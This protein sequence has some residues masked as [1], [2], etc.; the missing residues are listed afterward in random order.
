LIEKY[1]KPGK[2]RLVF[3]GVLNHAER[4]VHT[5]EAAHCAA[6]GGYGWH[7]HDLLFQNQNELWATS[8]DEHIALMKKYAQTFPEL[9]QAKFAACVE[10]REMLKTVQTIDQEQRARGITFQPIF[11]VGTARLAGAQPLEAFTKV[12]DAALV[13]NP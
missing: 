4:S 9:D 2:L 1:V 6:K 3:R 12:I 11:E 8:A 10:N 5:T 13:S 7:F